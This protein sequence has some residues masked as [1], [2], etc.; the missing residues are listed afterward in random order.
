MPR[1]TPSRPAARARLRP[2]APVAMGLATVWALTAAAGAVADADADARPAVSPGD[3]GLDAW[4]APGQPWPE[5]LDAPVTLGDDA[6]EREPP[7]GTPSRGRLPLGEPPLGAALAAVPGIDDPGA[8]FAEV[9]V[10]ALY[11]LEPVEVVLREA[12]ERFEVT[13]AT[14][15]DAEREV[16]VK[17][18]HTRLVTVPPERRTEEQKLVHREPSTRLVRGTPD[19]TLP[20]SSEELAAIASAGVDLDALPVGA[21]VNEW[22]EAPEARTIERRVLVSEAYEALDVAEATFEELSL[23]VEIA[24]AHARLVEIPATWTAVQRKVV[25][26]PATTA[27]VRGEGPVQRIDEA[28]GEI[29]CRIDVPA[30]HEVLN[31]AAVENPPMVTSIAQEATLKNVDVSRLAA[32]ARELR[33]PVAARF[34]VLE[35]PA[36]NDVEGEYLWLVGGARPLESAHERTGRAVC[37]TEVP[38][39]TVTWERETLVT[40]GRFE[41]ETVPAETIV[42][43]VQE[44]VADASSRAVPVP[45]ETVT[46]TRRTKL[47]DAH[48]AWRPVLC[49]TNVT[50]DVV[51][52]LQI[53]L[54][55]AGHSPNGIDGLLGPGT[56]GAVEAYQTERGLPT[57]GLT[58]E[59]LESL[60]VSLHAT[61]L[62]DAER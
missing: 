20:P 11:R 17:D 58:L 24:P 1:H 57:G 22:Y 51:R 9:Q 61:G 31:G 43:P 8:C 3:V 46:L 33:S 42:L 23:P 54:E 53:A 41:R 25:V 40:P 29:M 16:I 50:P 48:V 27:W 52:R 34:D 15:R 2:V 39:L 37:R 35:L 38:G 32:D 26:E 36:A 12:T 60:G 30:K 4:P 19:G 7:I 55:G 10:P 62:A 56:R 13:P 44:L 59:T 6:A 21:C 5:A 49:R 45:A 47:S 18:A 14:L 28:T